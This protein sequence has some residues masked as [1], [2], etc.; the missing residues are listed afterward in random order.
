MLRTSLIWMQIRIQTGRYNMNYIHIMNGTPPEFT[1]VERD[2]GGKISSNLKPSTQCI[3]AARRAG[4]ILT[5]I[6]RPFVYG[7]KRTFPQMYKQFV[8]CH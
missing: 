7:D 4:S 2:M 8:R 6:T 1:A 3:E 5:Q